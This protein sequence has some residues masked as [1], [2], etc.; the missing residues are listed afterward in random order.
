MDLE[1]IKE[2]Q[3]MEK[4]LENKVEK[5]KTMNQKMKAGFIVMLILVS[6]IGGYFI[7]NKINLMIGAKKNPIVVATDPT[8]TDPNQKPPVIDPNTSTDPITEPK[9]TGRVLYKIGTEEITDTVLA[10]E[11]KKIKPP[12]FDQ[13]MQGA[14]D[15]DK[16]V[17]L[18]QME[19]DALKNVVNQIYF[20]L[21]LK[22]QKI[23]ITQADL[24]KTRADLIDMMKK[25]HE[26]Q[27]TGTPFDLDARLSQYGITQDVFKEDIYNQS[28]YRIATA[29]FIEKITATEKEAKDFFAKHPELYNEPAKA[30][31]KHILLMSEAEADAV[32]LEL[33]QGADFATL[34]K[35]KSKDPQAQTNGGSIGFI[36]ND[37]TKV[38]SEILKVI[39]APNVP[40]NTPLKINVETQWYVMVV[41]SIQPPVIKSYTEMVDKAMYDVKEEKRKAALDEFLKKLEAKYGKPIA[42]K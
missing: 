21:Y 4:E 29:P 34:A 14:P 31:L 26:Q 20:K 23:S 35:S 24:D 17:Y 6:M 38:P 22:D 2:E 15:K 27:N 36:A 37:K 1:E 40:L 19:A 16:Q 42:Q 25:I 33:K 12:D 30:D 41:G 8:K 28:V 32:M 18:S 9:T 11:L 39:F 5:P 10:G 7:I 3:E 13:R